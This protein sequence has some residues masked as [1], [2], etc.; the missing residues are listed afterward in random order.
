[1]SDPTGDQPQVCDQCGRSLA[2]LPVPHIKRQCKEC[3]KTVHVVEPGEGGKGVRIREGDQFVIPAD[4]IRMSLDPSQST[5]QFFRGGVSV[6]VNMLYFE[7][8]PTTAEGLDLLLQQY[9]EQADRVVRGSSLLKDLD[10]DDPDDGKKAFELV[11]QR[12]D[13]PEWW[14]VV[15][16]SHVQLVRDYIQAGDPRKAAHAMGILANARAMLIFLQNLE[17]TVW[18]GY[19]LGNLR[20]VL[21]VWEANRNL[22]GRRVLADNVDPKPSCLIAGFFFS[23]HHPARQSVY[24]RDGPRPK[25]CEHCGL[26]VGQRPHREHCPSGDQDACN[27]IARSE[28]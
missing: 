1:M 8:M 9:E 5:G 10:I 20:R 16:S 13:L 7:G 22:R 18:R 4:F 11:K 3:G 26:P 14:A 23:R 21:D 25:R 17:E 2:P 28:I 19:T 24:R 12:D 6:F 15:V 27:K